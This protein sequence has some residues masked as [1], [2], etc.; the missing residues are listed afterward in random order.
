MEFV[1]LTLC[2]DVYHCRPSELRQERLGDILADLTCVSEEN[3][4][5]RIKAR[6]AIRTKR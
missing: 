1:R 5:A 4:V 6:N 3:R 2:R